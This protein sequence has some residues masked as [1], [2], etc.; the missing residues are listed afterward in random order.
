VTHPV[1]NSPNQGAEPQVTIPLSALESLIKRADRIDNEILELRIALG[2]AMLGRSV[3][4]SSETPAESAVE[5]QQPVAPTSAPEPVPKLEKT[6]Q[7]FSGV[8]AAIAE[9]TDHLT[10][11]LEQDLQKNKQRIELQG[12]ISPFV[13]AI[14]AE[15]RSQMADRVNAPYTPKNLPPMPNYVEYPE[16]WRKYVKKHGQKIK[17]SEQ[18]GDQKHRFSATFL[19]QPGA[20]E[21]VSFDSESEIVRPNERGKKDTY[22]P[23]W[24]INI[25]KGRLAGLEFRNLRRSQEN[26]RFFGQ[27]DKDFFEYLKLDT[28]PDI[29]LSYCSTEPYS[30]GTH[31][32]VYHPG[33]GFVVPNDHTLKLDTQAYSQHFEKVLTFMPVI[34]TLPSESSA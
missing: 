29:S 15:F 19:P 26:D 34:S 27:K 30:G 3:Q 10:P 32:Y 11:L 23:K 12:E 28:G 1:E 18:H 4:L 9:S 25:D 7:L 13:R 16:A 24:H 14:E 20:P 6:V 5:G 2:E 21:L 33:K 31:S 8:G 17:W 22:Y